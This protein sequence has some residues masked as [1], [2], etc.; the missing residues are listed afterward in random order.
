[1]MPLETTLRRAVPHL[2]SDE[3]DLTLTAFRA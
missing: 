1:V 2:T 3:I